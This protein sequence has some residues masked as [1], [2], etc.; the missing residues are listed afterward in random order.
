MDEELEVEKIAQAMFE[1]LQLSAEQLRKA[2]AMVYELAQQEENESTLY[3]AMCAMDA[4]AREVM[5][6]AVQDEA[7]FRAFMSGHIQAQTK[8][9]ENI[10]YC[11]RLMVGK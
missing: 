1:H 7:L 9:L 6:S 4:H 2:T 10:A 8:A 5:A 3:K 11:L